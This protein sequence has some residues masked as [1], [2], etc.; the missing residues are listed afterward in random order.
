MRLPGIVLLEQLPVQE[1]LLGKGRAVIIPGRLFGELLI[2]IP[3]LRI[4]LQ[5]IDH[6]VADRVG[7]GRLLTP[8]DF[9]RQDPV[10]REGFPDQV[11]PHLMPVH[12]QLR[13]NAHGIA[14]KLQI[15]EGNPGLQRID[16]NAPVRA[17]HVIYMQL[18]DALFRLLLKRRG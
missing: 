5:I 2:R 13:I 3:L 1:A 6:A 18:P 11:L 9:V 12:L 8:E 7:K 10:L 14:D 17:K 15:P 16:G 4:G